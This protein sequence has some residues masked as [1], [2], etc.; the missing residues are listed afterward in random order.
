[1]DT[2]S[3]AGLSEADETALWDLLEEAR[4]GGYIVGRPI[5]LLKRP[6]RPN[7]SW[8][9]A[10]LGLEFPPLQYRVSKAAVDRFLRL[11]A[12]V[13]GLPA[14]KASQYAPAALFADEPMQC[15]ATLFGRSGRLH[16]AHEMEILEP[17]PVDSLVRSR[18]RIA[19]RFERGGRQFVDVECVVHIVAGASE[20]PAL[21]IRATLL[22]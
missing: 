2:R 16:A 12:L 8:E 4:R 18:G 1:M 6:I 11:R 21:R 17:I 5:P 9:N 3:P 7:L 13:P 19:D 10:T 22:P 20:R 14:P 15:I